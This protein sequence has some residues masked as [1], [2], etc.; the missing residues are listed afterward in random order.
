MSDNDLN[1]LKL[2]EDRAT[3]LNCRYFNLYQEGGVPDPLVLV[4]QPDGST[5]PQLSRPLG[6]CRR[7]APVPNAQILLDG[8]K[9]VVNPIWPRVTE[10]DWCGEFSP[11]D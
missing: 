9:H 11:R 3:C 6:T 8:L 1:S 2:G 7:N 5:G 4:K 10:N